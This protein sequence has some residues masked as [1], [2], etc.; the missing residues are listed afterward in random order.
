MNPGRWS[1]ATAAVFAVA[2]AGHASAQ[3]LVTPGWELSAAAYT[4]FLPRDDNYLQPTVTADRGKLHLEGRFNYEAKRTASAWIGWNYEVGERVTF[5][6]TP[7]VG[8][9]FGDTNGIAPGYRTSLSWNW[10]ELSSEGEYVFA[11]ASR[12]DWFFYTWSEVGLY[13]FDWFGAGLV[14]QRTRAYDS[15]RD[16]QRGFFAAF[17]FPHVDVTGYVFNPDDDDVTYVLTVDVKFSLP[18]RR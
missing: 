11:S 4:Y 14:G 16:I 13:P 5:K 1:V 15:D 12:D 7:M 2:C 3:S 9:V 6:V 10:L 18:R 8:G 17:T